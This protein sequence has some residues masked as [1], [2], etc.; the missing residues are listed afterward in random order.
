MRSHDTR[1]G[2]LLKEAG[3]VRD[4]STGEVACDRYNRYREEVK[5]MKALGLTACRFSV[6]W[7][8]VAP[9]PGRI[10]EKGVDSCQRM[11]DALLEAGIQPWITSSEPPAWRRLRGR[12]GPLSNPAG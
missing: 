4:G 1:I 7:G 3:T 9:E 10:N 12:P 11:A 5:Q 8:R 2:E 6:G